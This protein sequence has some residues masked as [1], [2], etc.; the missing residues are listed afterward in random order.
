MNDLACR[1]ETWKIRSQNSEET[2]RLGMILGEML[3]PGS[4]VALQGELGSGKT[5]FA[6]G[7]ARGLG[8]SDETE[9]TSPS[10]VLVNEYRGRLPVFHVDLYRLEKASQMEDLGYEEFIFGDGVTLVE[11][12]EKAGHLL[13]EDRIDVHMKWTGEEE[14]EISLRT[15]GRRMEGLLRH[16]DKKWKKGE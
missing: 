5:V 14:R 12:P 15:R 10:F 11:W 7:V 16:L 6:K 1:E 2:L 4:V 3:S 9:V 13:P 8:I